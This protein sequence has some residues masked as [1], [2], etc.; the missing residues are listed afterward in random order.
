VRISRR[1][2][3]AAATSA[4]V[5][6]LMGSGLAAAGPTWTTYHGD[7]SRSGVDSNEA[8]L[9]PLS[10]GWT[11]TLDNA[12]VY[13]QPV[14]AEG[15]VFVATENDDVYALRADTG[16]VLW[17][18]SIG[19]PLIGVSGQV[20]CGNIDPL[21]I[22]S[23]PVIDMA[24]ETLYVV[25]EVSTGGKLPIHHQ[26]VGFNIFTGQQVLSD[27]VDPSP[28]PAGET[29][30]DLKDLQQRAA[31][32]VANGKVYVAFGGLYGD[33]GNYH[34]WVVAADESGRSPNID[35]DASPT[36]NDAAIWNGGGGP[37]IDSAGNVY[38]VTG[39]GN[40]AGGSYP[41]SVVKLNSDLGVLNSYPDVNASGDADLGTGDALLL[42]DGN[43]FTVGKTNHGYVLSQSGLGLVADIPGVCGNDPDGG[44]TY[45]AANNTV[46][47]PCSGGHIQ[48]VD[49]NTNAL[50]P[51]LGSVNGS[52][53][54]VNG[55]L[56]ALGYND[57]ELQEID[58]GTGNAKTVVSNLNLPN[59]ATPTAADG[60]L[61]FGTKHGVKAYFGPGGP[62][63]P[64]SSLPPPPAGY[65][66]VASDGGVFALGTSSFLGS[67]GNL[68][69]VAP[70][71]GAASTPDGNGYWLVASDGG[72]FAF[73][74]AKF[75][76][77]MGGKRLNQPVVGMAA[78][79]N[80]DGY[81]L[82][83][84]DGGI[85]SFGAA[86]FYG[87]TG[88]IR[89]NRPIVGMAMD[90][91][92]GGYWLVASDGGVFSYNASFYGST[93]ALHLAQPVV[94]MAAAS[95][96]NGYWLVASDGGV[97]AF[98]PGAG[99]H[100]SVGGLPLMS[101]VV[102]MAADAKTG[103]YWLAA[104]DAGVFAFGAPFVGSF[105]GAQLAQPVVAITEP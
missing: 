26:L 82:V 24:N 55:Q 22:T 36:A 39:N 76:G 102:G 5:F 52:P 40:L 47:V 35:F 98:G 18:A 96:G 77:S 63:G 100:G 95:G 48:A 84:K 30:A 46:Y 28:L 1:L 11:D 83:A 3:W 13:G 93:G 19:A 92:S 4:A 32:A 69:L 68:H 86:H 85:F 105:G 17:S 91:A 9:D 37:S 79:P 81:W 2:L 7:L 16:Q 58:P 51:L 45:D 103:G 97:F 87:S 14:V 38:V 65:R 34:G 70:I 31:L 72:V 89:I 62:P 54:L 64:P 23:T 67:L 49:L 66:L 27:N 8:A 20:G 99:F 43:L 60:T 104:A 88:A 6:T 61:V 12:A 78:T 25:G 73:G 80:G 90:P 71:V 41:N 53:I 15:R 42:P 10:S 21:G 74:T 101:P 75:Y 56:W 33:C 29:T 59:F 57:G 44:A 94:G 50:G